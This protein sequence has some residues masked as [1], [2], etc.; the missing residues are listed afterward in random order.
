MRY[1][2]GKV[3]GLAIE[4]HLSLLLPLGL[5]ALLKQPDGLL[6]ALLRFALSLV[7]VLLHELAHLAVGLYFGAQ[8]QGISLRPFAGLSSL[9]EPPHS[10]RG[11]VVTTLA[12]PLSSLFLGW[13][14]VGFGSLT[15]FGTISQVCKS[16]GYTTLYWTVFNLLPALPMDAG[17]LLWRWQVC[18][19]GNLSS[20]ADVTAITSRIIQGAVVFLGFVT[21]NPFWFAL[22]VYLYFVGTLEIAALMRET[23]SHAATATVSPP[24]YADSRPERVEIK[25]LD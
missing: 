14:L 23:Q 13:L 1:P 6:G 19:S 24:P 17:R 10:V 2:L 21:H 3:R 16:V 18:V 4:A 9:S 5:L 11:D 12:G 20:A 22:A 15:P 8:P 7:V 25:R